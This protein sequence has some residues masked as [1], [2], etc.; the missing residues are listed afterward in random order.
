M[1]KQLRV[2]AWNPNNIHVLVDTAEASVKQFIREEEPDIVFFP[3]CKPGTP[4]QMQSATDKLSNI[5]LE[6]SEMEWNFFWNVYVERPYLHGNMVAIKKNIQDNG[7]C[8]LLLALM[9]LKSNLIL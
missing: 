4:E 2:F 6:A 1:R 9:F 5:F 7:C 8:Y 3:E